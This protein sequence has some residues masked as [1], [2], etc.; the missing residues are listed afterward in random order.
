MVRVS[1]GCI[2]GLSGLDLGGEGKDLDTSAGGMNGVG[3]ISDVTQDMNDIDAQGT[4]NEANSEDCFDMGCD[5]SAFG[6]EG[7]HSGGRLQPGERV[8]LEG[9][10]VYGYGREG[11]WQR[12]RL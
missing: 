5:G 7:R 2:Y 4:S 11:R 1:F 3:G 9:R 10:G 8:R 12:L 6:I